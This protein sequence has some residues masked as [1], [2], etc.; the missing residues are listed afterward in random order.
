MIIFGLQYIMLNVKI[1]TLFSFQID[2]YFDEK[3]HV[4]NYWESNITPYVLHFQLHYHNKNVLKSSSCWDFEHCYG[5][6][7]LNLEMGWIN[8]ILVRDGFYWAHNMDVMNTWPL[9]KLQQAKVQD[10]PRYAQGF[11]VVTEIL[12]GTTHSLELVFLTNWTPQD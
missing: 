2:T 3:C 10:L 9:R 11:V 12:L 8:H 7:P 6:H 4:G 5:I 1:H